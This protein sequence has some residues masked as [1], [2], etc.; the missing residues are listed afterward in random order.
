MNSGRY[1]G[2]KI[3]LILIIFIISVF[4]GVFFGSTGSILGLDAGFGELFNL[5]LPRVIAALIT[6]GALAICGAALQSVLENPLAEPF[7]LGVSGGSVL[8]GTIWIVS[9]AF[10]SDSVFGI[11]FFSFSGA[12]GSIFLLLYINRRQGGL[13]PVNMLLTGV[14]FNGF[15]S[16]L[17]TI[18]KA[19][20]PPVKL[21]KVTLW[22][23]GYIP[24]L[25]LNDI[26]LETIVVLVIS[27]LLVLESPRLNILALGEDIARTSGINVGYLRKRVFIYTSLLTGIVVSLTGLIGF[28]GLIIPQML[29]FAGIINNRYLLPLS[30]FAG[31]A[32][33]VLSDLLSRVMSGLYSFEPPI[34]AITAVI[35]CPVFVILLRDYY[36]E[37][38]GV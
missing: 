27:F 7:L 11:R 12:I 19:F 33:V 16:A 25:S 8:G 9:G 22:L 35:G 37:R 29:R 1:T 26:L 3:F 30:F 10:I 4:L 24:Y 34:S 21:Q 18:F 5:R 23:S 28:V 31:G 2:L 14:I 36:R 6:G 17:V 20:I 13:S 32:F 38:G 15:V